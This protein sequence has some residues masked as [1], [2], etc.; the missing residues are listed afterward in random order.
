[1]NL[2]FNDATRSQSLKSFLLPS[3]PE[4]IFLILVSIVLLTAL[5][6]NAV[7]LAASSD[8]GVSSEVAAEAAQPQFAALSNFLSQEV[9][10][11]A[12][13][14]LLWGCIGAVAYTIVGAL[15]HFAENVQHDVNA[16]Q[17][18][19]PKTP[20]SYWITRSSQYVYVAAILFL[21]VVFVGIMLAKILPMCVE[22]I[23]S[24]IINYRNFSTYGHALAAVSITAVSLLILS[25]LWKAVVYSFRVTFA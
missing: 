10:A 11:K 1:M 17:Y 3:L 4:V 16:S 15:I 24:T 14:F 25:R 23:S 13:V 22:G 18:V 6:H 8:A 20:R 12:T 2:G 19:A 7:W 9:F 5:S 21:F